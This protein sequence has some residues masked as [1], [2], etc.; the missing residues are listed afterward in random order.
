MMQAAELASR[1]ARTLLANAHEPEAVTAQI[2]GGLCDVRV[3]AGIQRA[4]Q[5]TALLL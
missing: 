5:L 3:L 2:S 1:F 4:Q